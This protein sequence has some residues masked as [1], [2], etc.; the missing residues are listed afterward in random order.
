M[1][2]VGALFLMVAGLLN[3]SFQAIRREREQSQRGESVRLALTRVACELREA[4]EIY[5]LDDA[6]GLSFGKTHLDATSNTVK[7]FRV[8]YQLEGSELIRNVR[9]LSSGSEATYLAAEH[10]AGFRCGSPTAGA[11]TFNNLEVSLTFADQGRQVR[12]VSTEVCP[13][14]LLGPITP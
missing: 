6:S 14:A 1:L 3:D 2:L 7:A 8:Q 10:V 9:D 4:T 5:S 12:T 11:A 13:L